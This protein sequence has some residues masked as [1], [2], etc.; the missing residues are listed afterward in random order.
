MR[1]GKKFNHL[2]RKTA[3]RRALLSNLANA[4]IE[5][6][7]I[8]TTL[9]KAKALRTYVEPIINKAKEDTTH[10]R[11]MA[12]RYLKSK[13][14]IKE[15]FGDIAIKIADRPGGYTRV[16][17]MG[18]RLGDG[19][20]MAMIELVDYNDI[21]STKKKEE[22]KK[23]TRRSRRGGSTDASKASSPAEDKVTKTTED[24][25]VEATTETVEEV[26]VEETQVEETPVVEAADETPEAE[27]KEDEPTDDE[28]KK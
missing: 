1:H 28:E 24:D 10:Q 12:F 19:A 23:T 18:S 20:E 7:S 15:L 26:V 16:I 14:A 5:H 2:G 21:Y 25:Q 22:T 4:L 9:A 3:H 13:E 8:K 11:R 27:Q 6:K 17:R